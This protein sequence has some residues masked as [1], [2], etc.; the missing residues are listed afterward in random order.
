MANNTSNYIMQFDKLYSNKITKCVMD[1][2]NSDQTPTSTF[3][4]C[5][6]QLQNLTWNVP[7]EL[8]MILTMQAQCLHLLGLFSFWFAG[9]S[10][11]VRI[12]HKTV[13]KCA[14]SPHPHPP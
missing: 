14:K 9:G 4:D 8:C 6:H 13:Q 2:K 11:L 7:I 12:V 10:E 1:F 5:R 3:K